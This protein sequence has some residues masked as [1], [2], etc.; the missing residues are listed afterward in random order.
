MLSNIDAV[1]TSVSAEK[2]HTLFNR[3][4]YR[5]TVALQAYFV[6]PVRRIHGLLAFQSTVYFTSQPPNCLV[7]PV[8]QHD[9]FPC[10]DPT[11]GLYF[12]LRR[13]EFCYA[14]KPIL[15]ALSF[16]SHRPSSPAEA[17][18]PAGMA[19]AIGYLVAAA[20]LYCLGL[21]TMPSTAGVSC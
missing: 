13:C 10:N 5:P 1:V 18:A 2:N 17:G 20:G 9:A 16:Q 4:V 11:I 14:A 19:Q 15:L 7:C 6:S 21:F 8:F 3:T 12:P